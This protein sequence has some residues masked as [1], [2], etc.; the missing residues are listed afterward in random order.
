VCLFIIAKIASVAATAST[1]DPVVNTSLGQIKGLQL[2]INKVEVN[3]Y[4]GIPFALPPTGQR[5]FADPTDWTA[6]F[7]GGTFEALQAGN[8][9]ASMQQSGHEDCLYLNIWAPA[10]PKRKG[11]LPVLFFIHGGSFTSGN[12]NQYNMSTLAAKHDA[13][14]MSTNYRLGHFGWLQPVAG[15]GNFG[16]K[17]QRSALRWVQREIQHFGGDHLKVLVSGAACAV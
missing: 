3:Q 15:L 11:P 6:P 16:L 5:R 12:G 10:I 17:D 13:I 14:Y 4:M 7:K 1:F 9:C 2:S 8:Q